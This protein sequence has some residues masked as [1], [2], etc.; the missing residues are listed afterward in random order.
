MEDRKNQLVQGQAKL[1]AFL[2]K[3]K[4]EQ[5]I[6]INPIDS[7]SECVESLNRQISS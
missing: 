4:R 3:L 1:D 6:A 2:L 7:L 5:V